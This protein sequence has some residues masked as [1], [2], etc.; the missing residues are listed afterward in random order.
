MSSIYKRT[1]RA[2]RICVAWIG[3]DGKQR[4]KM[5]PADTPRRELKKFAARMET[6]AAAG[7]GRI[8]TVDLQTAAV[9]FLEDR[10]A[11]CQP[12]T[13]E[14]YRSMLIPFARAIGPATPLDHVTTHALGEWRNARLAKGRSPVTV[15]SDLK[16]LTAFFRFCV[17]RSWLAASPMAGVQAPKYKRRIP[18]FLRPDEME[19]FIAAARAHPRREFYL[20]AVLACDLGLRR[21]E[22]LYLQWRD[23]DFDR[24][25]ITI[26]G[27]SK[28]PR[29]LPLTQRAADA[30]ADWGQEGPLVFPPKYKTAHHRS[31]FLAKEFNRFIAD[32]NL[33]IKSEHGLRHSFG[34]RL[35]LRG[36]SERLA[37]DALGHQTTDT[38]RLYL[39]SVTEVL[40]AAMDPQPS[41]PPPP[42][43][44]PTP[45]SPTHSP[46]TSETQKPAAP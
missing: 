26:T 30:L 11:V 1:D 9:Y 16:I 8:Q 35:M 38:T 34:T 22:M 21:N 14:R 31:P 45:K 7:R 29:V 32:Q 20:L 37:A 27:K 4:T 41:S 46:A 12:A 5:F 17:A 42:A 15:R 24:R 13:H 28:D 6:E 18:G 33:P 43:T 3:A 10:G 19:T 2:G 39:H 36:A 25:L 23:I 40:R 44:T